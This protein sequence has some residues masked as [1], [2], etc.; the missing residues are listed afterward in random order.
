[1]VGALLLIA[2][3]TAALMKGCAGSGGSGS[4]GGTKA[5]ADTVAFI[6]DAMPKLAKLLDRWNNGNQAGAVKLWKS[7]GTVS[8]TTAAD[9]VLTDAYLT[10]ANNVRYYMIGDGSV[11][12]KE[13]EASRTKAEETLTSLRP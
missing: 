13:L 5:S 11:N 7:I 2:L 6:D 4:A 1:M 12:L 8:L 10:Y 3:T 9:K